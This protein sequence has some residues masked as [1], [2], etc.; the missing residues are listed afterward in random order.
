MSNTDDPGIE[1]RVRAATYRDG[2]TELFA[3]AVLLVMAL[4]W[5]ANPAVIGIVAAFIVLYGWRLVETLKRRITYPRM[6][7]YQDRSEEPKETA[8]GILVFCAG[9]LVVMVGVI[10]LSGGITEAAEWRRAAPLLSGLVLSGALWYMGD[11]SGLKRHRF[12]AIFSVVM[13]V[14]IWAFTSGADYEGMVWHLLSLVAVLGALGTWGI[15]HFI[16]T[17][18]AQ[19]TVTDA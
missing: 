4:L 10:A 9:A 18:P 3:A 11:R 13:G 1:L 17:Y 19:N 12:V 8:R 7:Y 14:L 16:R 6:G 5:L 15:V 2:L